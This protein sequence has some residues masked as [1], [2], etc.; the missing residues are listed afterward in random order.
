MATPGSKRRMP[1]WHNPNLQALAAALVVLAALLVVWWQGS[2]WYHGRLVAHRRDQEAI[3]AGIYANA[4]SLAIEQQVG[5]FRELHAYMQANPADP[6]LESH[7]Q[8]YAKALYT[9][10]KGIRALLVAPGG[11][12]AFVY[13]PA[14]NQPVLG[15]RPADDPR[16]E[17]RAVAERAFDTG[18]VVLSPPLALPRSSVGFMAYQAI[19]D[20]VGD[21]GLIGMLLD[22]SALL[23]DTGLP[24]RTEALDYAL[25]DG[26]SKVI[27]GTP[28]VFARTPVT[29]TVPLPEGS[30]QLGY[31]PKEGWRVPAEEYLAFDLSGLAIVLLL[32]GLTYLVTNRQQRLARDVERRLAEIAAVNARLQ[33]AAL[34]ERQRLARDLHD[35]VSQALYGIG[36]GAQTARRLLEREPARAAEPLDYVLS[37]TKS[38][39]AEM[40]ALI[41]ELRPNSLEHEGLAVALSRQA[42]AVA[43]R[44]GLQV[45]M[46]LSAEPALSA[47]AREALYR[48]AQEALN[49]VARHAQATHVRLAMAED[50]GAVTLTVED[51]GTGFDPSLPYPGHMGLRSMSERAEQVGGK[52]EIR[53]APG[54]GTWLSVRIPGKGTLKPS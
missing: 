9:G 48:I 7:F 18:R 42:E 5:R 43:A 29:A 21:W 33:A 6:Q 53:S 8:T 32:T 37:L 52:L 26:S 38:A 24:A 30:W 44:H 27:Y 19:R 22:V 4:L 35:S 46:A 16:P 34:E 28:E 45:E 1:L 47:E 20:D 15:Y 2:R 54:Q 12:V 31:V 41:F 14:G 40:R 51:D 10:S 13:P 11:T 25:R 3:T 39:I 36:L 17:L 49:N 23:D 50:A